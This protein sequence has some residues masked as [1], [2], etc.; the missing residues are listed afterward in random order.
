MALAEKQAAAERWKTW[1]A[2]ELGREI[3]W[4]DAEATPARR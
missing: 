3:T 4:M 2:E 1:S